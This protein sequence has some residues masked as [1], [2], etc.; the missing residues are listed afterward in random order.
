MFALRASRHLLQLLSEPALSEVPGQR[1][2]SLARSAPP[3]TSAHPLCP[4]RVHAPA[5]VS[6]PGLTEQARDLQPVVPR[7][8]RDSADSRSRSTTSRRGDRLLQRAAHLEPTTAAPSA[9]SLCRSGRRTGSR[10]HPLDSGA[11][12]LLLAS[13]SPEPRL[14]GQVCG[15]SSETAQRGATRF[16]RNLG[17]SSV[18]ASLRRHAPIAVPVRLGGL[19]QTPFWWRRTCAALSELLHPS[20]VDL[21]SPTG[22]L[23]RGPGPPPSIGF[24][25]AMG[26]A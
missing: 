26:V 10:S 2:R 16:S 9:C 8:C 3:G 7:Q 23:F 19:F 24:R 6:A 5:P 13:Q 1:A 21:Q 14:P 17:A 18:S 22:G 25:H 11:T 20:R 4:R 15:W 12:R